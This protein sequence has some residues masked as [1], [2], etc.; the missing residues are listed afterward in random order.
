MSWSLS[1]C[2]QL[3]QSVFIVCTFIAMNTNLNIIRRWVRKSHTEPWWRFSIATAFSFTLLSIPDWI[4]FET[5][6]SFPQ[7]DP[8]LLL[9]IIIS[10]NYTA[11]NVSCMLVRIYY[12]L[13]GQLMFVCFCS[14]PPFTVSLARLLT[15]KQLTDN[16]VL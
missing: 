14:R 13:H 6:N 4:V 7:L 10:G 5:D 2:L 9:I 8:K 3:N 11:D 1:E 16:Y 12:E 15:Y